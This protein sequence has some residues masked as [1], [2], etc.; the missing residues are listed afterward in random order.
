MKRR[1]FVSRAT[2]GLAALHPLAR[3]LF[4]P[5]LSGAGWLLVPMDDVQAD[6]L[7]AYGLTYRALKRGVRAEWFLNFRNGSFLLPADAATS[8]DAALAGGTLQPM[9][10]GGLAEIR[11]P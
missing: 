7:K 6:H 5:Q 9:D 11:G 3:S 10:D 2:A 4:P 1:E 8:R